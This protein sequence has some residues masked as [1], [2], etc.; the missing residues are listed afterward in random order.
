MD[1]DQLR[2]LV[3]SCFA[4]CAALLVV[5]GACTPLA[6]LWQDGGRK[7]RLSRRAFWA[8]GEAQV[9]GG[10]Q[11]F[12]GLACFG[13]VLLWRRDYG[14]RHLMGLGFTLPQVPA[15]QG[16]VTGIFRL[17][18]RAGGAR[19]DGVFYGRQ[20]SFVG[21]V[22]TAGRFVPAAPRRLERTGD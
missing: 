2:L 3:L 9:D 14:E 1:D 16:R 18:L 21:E 7:L 10:H 22:P 4:A 8:F 20:F 15:L 19:L 13:L 12:S 5:G 17:R 6:G 11:R